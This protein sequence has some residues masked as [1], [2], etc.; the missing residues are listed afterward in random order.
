MQ[1]QIKVTGWTDRDRLPN[2]KGRLDRLVP[3]QNVGGASNSDDTVTPPVDATDPAVEGK[4]HGMLDLRHMRLK[5]SR[6]HKPDVVVGVSHG[7]RSCRTSVW[8]A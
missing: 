3:T 7:R 5:K 4:I 6:C 8:D 1:L 2:S